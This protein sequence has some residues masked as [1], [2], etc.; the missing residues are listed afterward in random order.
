MPASPINAAHEAAGA[1]FTDFGGWSMP[2]QYRGVLE[3][4]ASVRN[5]VGVFD[6]SHLGRFE[7]RGPG[8]AELLR[9]QLCNDIARIEPGRAQYTMALN[10]RGGVEDDI[11]VWYLDTDRLWVMP[12]GTNSDGIIRRFAEA[13]PNSV[14]I[15]DVRP[16]TALLAVQGP[17]APDLVDR[18][19]GASPG[20]FRVMSSAF[21]D[22]DATVAGTG[23]TGERGAEICVPAS[24][25]SSL[26]NA[27]VAEG[28]EPCGLGARDTL[29]LEMGYPLWG[30]D[31]DASTTPI[32]AGLGWVVAWN[33][34]FVGREAL[35]KQR[36][37]GVPRR[38]IAFT[39]EGRAIP[40]HGYPVRSESG[41]GSVSSG[42]YSPTLGHGI[43]MAYVTPPPGPDETLTVEIR[44]NQVPATR[45]D[46]PFVD[47]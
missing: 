12:N 40:R 29:R 31:L 1:R 6:V 23:Y 39:T 22:R 14:S 2:V 44:G 37:V 38:L 41:S 46:L 20:R 21:E 19:I 7:V 36:D 33:H 28:A 47:R 3:E 30:Q 25:A 43:G 32:E 11:I 45:V 9:S 15:T 4:H 35:A 10:P 34:D 24:A 13:A 17:Q 16:D 8:S 26:W 5:A 42:N 27:I 18:V